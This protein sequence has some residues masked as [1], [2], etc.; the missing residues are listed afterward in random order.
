MNLR[1]I[2]L[3]AGILG[4]IAFIHVLLPYSVLF[5]S[6]A[7]NVIVVFKKFEH[8]LSARAELDAYLAQAGIL[9]PILVIN[10]NNLYLFYFKTK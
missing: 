8:L 9:G 10:R 7:Q 3:A 2:A 1:L 4:S 5:H 6:V